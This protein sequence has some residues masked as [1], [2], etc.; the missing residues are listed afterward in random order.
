MRYIN[1]VSWDSQ[2][3]SP[4]MIT[5]TFLEKI[6]LRLLRWYW[7]VSWNVDNHHLVRWNHI[8]TWDENVTCLTRQFGIISGDSH[9]SSQ[10]A[11]DVNVSWDVNYLILRRLFNISWD[12][13]PSSREAMGFHL[14]R[15][16]LNASWNVEK[17][18][19][20]RWDDI[21]TWDEKVICLLKRFQTIS[22]DDMIS[23]QTTINVIAPRDANISFLKTVFQQPLRW[24]L[25]I[26]W[27]D[28]FSPQEPSWHHPMRVSLISSHGTVWNHHM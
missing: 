1:T 4:E 17:H 26:S 14:T 19:L 21:I 22:W 15:W 3:T 13:R 6:I 10:I 11:I 7:N 16:F 8:I 25:V 23:S 27:G 2:S 20:V 24:Y 12:D 28:E 9:I 5:S 18:D